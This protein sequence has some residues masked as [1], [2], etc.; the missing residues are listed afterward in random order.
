VSAKPSRGLGRGL[1]ALLPRPDGGGRQMAL[2][3]AE[4]V[5]VQP[6]KRFDEEAIAEMAASI[7]EKGVLQPLLVRPVGGGYEIV[8]GE[9]RLP[10]RPARGPH[11]RS[12]RRSGAQRPPG[13]GDRHHREPPARG[14]RRSRGGRGVPPA[15]RLR[16]HPGGGGQGRREEPVR[17]RQHPAAV[18]AAGGC[19]GGARRQAHHRRP[20]ARDPRARARRPR[21]GACRRCCGGS[22]RCATPSRCAVR[23][24]GRAAGRSATTATTRWPAP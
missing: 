20:R 24:N 3:G 1:D 14:P 12:R 8:A 21:L 6:R 19:G 4:G 9:R 2:V 7:A 23:R 11:Q 16:T 5:D 17:G 18:D 13:A 15:A 10:G 22:S